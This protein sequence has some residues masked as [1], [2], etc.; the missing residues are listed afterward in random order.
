MLAA[1]YSTLRTSLKSYCDK[2]SDYN[3]TIIITRKDEKNVVLMSLEQYNQLTKAA[4]NTDYLA[5]LDKSAGQIS[6]G[7]VIV[8]T[9]KVLEK[10]AK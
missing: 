4:R 10:L 8:K 3:E 9:M 2:A 7:K 6:E 1:N 5:K